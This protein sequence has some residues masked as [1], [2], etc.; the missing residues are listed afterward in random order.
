MERKCNM[1]RIRAAAAGALLLAFGL[2]VSV[3][4]NLP[5]QKH[6]GE[7]VQ[8]APVRGFLNMCPYEG[9]VYCGVNGTYGEPVP[10]QSSIFTIWEDKLYYVEKVQEAY[11]SLTDELQSIWRS[12]MDGSNEELLAEDVFLA[13]AGHE[14]LIGDK[15]FYGY[16]YDENYRM[17][18]AC[19]D[20]NTKERT[21]IASDRI[22]TILGYDGTYLYY[23]G[24]DGREETNVLGRIHVA[25]GK[26]ETI[27][28]YA[29]ADEE[30][31]IDSVQY[32]DG[33]LYCFTL[34]KKPD[35]YDYRTYE[36]RLAV[37]DAADGS[38]K[39]ELPVIFTGTANYSFLIQDGEAY[40][41]LGGEITAISLK[42]GSRRTVVSM[43][44][45][46]Y[47]GILHFIPGDGYLYY[48]AISEACNENGSNDFFYRVPVKGGEK[49]LLKEWFM[50]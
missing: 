24:I 21:E 26:D 16:G 43:E 6:E 42:D 45:E 31:Y 50:I 18:Y 11:D 44:P 19:V 46:E 32:A 8:T 36:Y 28:S 30:G 33:Q 4:M 15:L 12:D 17:R 13:G 20:V 3:Q 7:P 2:A 22:D 47:W 27:C 14:Q 37:R 9:Q 35:S 48:E 5:A 23:C 25:K 41:T 49:E 29:A 40:V 1:T 38:V 39:Q 10:K 34:T